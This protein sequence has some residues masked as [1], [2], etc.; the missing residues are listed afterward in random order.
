MLFAAVAMFCHQVPS[1]TAVMHALGIFY[2][3]QQWDVIP[4]AA[5]ICRLF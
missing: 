2:Y 3:W 1:A 5:V 4:R